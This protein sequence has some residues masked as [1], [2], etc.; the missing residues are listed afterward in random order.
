MAKDI[1]Y[2]QVVLQRTPEPNSG[3]ISTVT[4]IPSNLARIGKFVELKEGKNWTTWQVVKISNHEL[5]A[6]QAKK[7][8]EKHHRGWNN[9][10]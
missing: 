1:T 7:L 2:K 4:H 10:I 6:E 8:A 5:S 3:L 9:N